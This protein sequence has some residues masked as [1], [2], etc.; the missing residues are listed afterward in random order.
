MVASGACCYHI[1]FATKRRRC[2]LEGEIEEKVKQ[3]LLE[4][5]R[6]RGIDLLQCETMFDHVHLLLRCSPTDLSRSVFLLKGTTA[7]R[8]FQAYPELKLDASTQSFR[9][10]RYGA[11]VVPETALPSLKEYVAT[12]KDRP[13]KYER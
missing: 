3:L 11:K 4:T 13:E 8:V 9:Q 10:A 12:Q 2:L 5:A 6:R 7:R 1:W